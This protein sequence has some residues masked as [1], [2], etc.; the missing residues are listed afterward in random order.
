LTHWD[1]AAQNPAYASPDGVL[2]DRARS[3][4]IQ[5]PPGRSGGC[6]PPDSLRCIADYAFRNNAGLTSLRLPEGFLSIGAQALAGCAGLSEL[7]LPRSTARIGYGA[8]EG[9][10]GI[11]YFKGPAPRFD[12]SDPASVSVRYCLGQPGWEA[13]A[14]PKQPWTSVVFFQAGSG[15]PSYPSA[16]GY[17]GNAYG[18][19]PAATHPSDCFAGWRTEPDG[20]GIHVYPSSLVPYVTTNHVLYAQWAASPPIGAEE[21]VTFLPE[22]ICFR[23]P[24]G[25]SS[26]VIEHATDVTNGTWSFQPLDPGQYTVTDRLV[27]LS[28][29]AH[30]PRSFFR[31][32]FLP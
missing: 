23:L 32:R 18:E 27:S 15:I 8:F 2:M 11:L 16:T 25:Y 7:V 3:V 12:L 13:V 10:T 14:G 4:L 28:Y 21:E 26:C 20:A 6:A 19:L 29:P 22:L 9:V 31:A 1:V 30:H 17:V 5:F 24:V